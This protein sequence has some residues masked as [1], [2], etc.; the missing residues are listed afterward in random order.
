MPIDNNTPDHD[1]LSDDSYNRHADSN[2]DISPTETSRI[3][4]LQ[5]LLTTLPVAPW[6]HSQKEQLLTKNN[7][8]NP[9]F[10]LLFITHH[11]LMIIAK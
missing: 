3:G 5:P 4:D 9:W 2:T 8:E 11:T 7:Q 10:I 6:W 1:H